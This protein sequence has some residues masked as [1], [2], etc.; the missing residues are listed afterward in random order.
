MCPAA[1]LVLPGPWLDDQIFL[2]SDKRSS[3]GG[4]KLWAQ[5][6]ALVAQSNNRF[7]GPPSYITTVNVNDSLPLN[8]KELQNSKLLFVLEEIWIVNKLWSILESSTHHLKSGPQKQKGCRS[9]HES[10]F[11]L[12][13]TLIFESERRCRLIFE[14]MW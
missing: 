4:R 2:F 12:D 11:F 14:N 5:I 6:E 13:W 3:M 7:F 10:D 1:D 9:G 8:E